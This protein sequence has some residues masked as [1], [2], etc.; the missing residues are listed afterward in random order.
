MVGINAWV[1]H[2]NTKVFGHDA[3][4]FRP[5][6]WLDY[7]EQVRERDSYFMTV[8]DNLNTLFETII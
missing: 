6:R 2:A 8:N 5:E 3:H 4:M 7:P 1:A